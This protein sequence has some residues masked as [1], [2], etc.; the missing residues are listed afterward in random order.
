MTSLIRAE[1][2][3]LTSRRLL[4]VLLLLSVG[5]ILVVQGVNFVKSDRDVE[6]ARRRA[7]QRFERDNARFREQAQLECERAKA[8]GNIPA[9]VDCSR[10][11]GGFGGAG[12]ADP[13]LFA[14]DAL[15]D[16]TLAVAVG[17]LI[18][19]FAIGASSIGAEWNAGTL[20]AL[21]FWEPRRG[22][23]LL[24]KGVA[25]LAVLFVFALAMQALVYATTMLTASTRGSAAG[26]TGGLHMSN[27]L[28]MLR[29]LIGLTFTG[30]LG[31]GVTGLARHTG[32]ALGAGFVYFS[33]IEQVVGGL[34]PGLQRY[35]MS[36]NVAAI[37]TERIELA[38]SRGH[39][40][41]DEFGNLTGF[42]LTS[43]RGTVTLAI[44]LAALLGAF[45]VVFSRRDVT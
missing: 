8:D 29:G 15:R 20:Q 40:G 27:A 43:T 4:R 1:I 7:E 44:Y 25:L 38:D 10:E 26:V 42:V 3:R 28:T 19:G 22:R 11:L 17:T 39:M 23:V 14:K 35:L 32:A 24:A 30:L 13:R 41:G 21:L 16:G 45:Y 2:R 6:G 12:F 31:F 9:E 37:V 5:L 18:L 34:R 33:I 36:P